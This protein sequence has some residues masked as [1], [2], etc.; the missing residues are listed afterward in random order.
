[1]TLALMPRRYATRTGQIAVRYRIV[2]RG[3]SEHLPV[4]PL[5][6]MTVEAEGENSVLV[7]D[8]VDQAQLQGVLKWLSDLGIEIVSVNPAEAPADAP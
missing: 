4:G 8:I 7:G 1:M 5:E 2:V 6:C 3:T